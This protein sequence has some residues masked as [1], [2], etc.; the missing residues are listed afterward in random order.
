[1][2]HCDSCLDGSPCTDSAGRYSSLGAASEALRPATL[3]CLENV[4]PSPS[5]AVSSLANIPA[6]APRMVPRPPLPPLTTMELVLASLGLQ[7]KRRLTVRS[8]GC[9]ACR[10]DRAVV[11]FLPICSRPRLAEDGPLAVP[12][13]CAAGRAALDRGVVLCCGRELLFGRSICARVPS[14]EPQLV[15]LGLRRR[16]LQRHLHH[17]PLSPQCDCLPG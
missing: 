10:R 16:E 3:F 8:G 14:L 11:C 1:M 15:V 4:R 6:M 13:L 17:L 12:L 5:T 9:T 2:L 7:L